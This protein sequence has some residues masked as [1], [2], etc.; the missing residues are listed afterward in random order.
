MMSSDSRLYL[1]NAEVVVGQRYTGKSPVKPAT[2]LSFKTRT[3]FSVEKTV[4]STPNNA[5]V[6]IYN[7]SQQSRT[8]LEQKNM[9]L[10]L[11]VGY[12]EALS[13]LFIGDITR[14]ETKRQGADVITS[15]ESG[16]GELALRTS[17][18]EISLEANATNVQAM[19]AAIDALNITLGSTDG[20]KTKVYKKGF[21]FSG[22]A[23]ELLDTLTRQLNLEW[24]VQDGELIILP[25]NGPDGQ[26][27]VVV[28]PDT[29]LI[30]FPTKTK[31]GL[32]FVSL[33]NPRIRPGRVVI[34]RSKQFYGVEM[35][36]SKFIASR[37]LKESGAIVKC[38]RVVYEGDTHEG[39]WQVKVEAIIPPQALEAYGTGPVAMAEPLR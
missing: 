7:L 4:E 2:G 1:R 3:N 13:T 39:N 20:I 27:A 30:G 34:V 33:L 29:G 21:T 17:H 12:Q 35:E 16:D 22:T 11:S 25:K 6:S 15:I 26:E 23:K 18:V 10:F 38:K 36:Q 32:E 8:F 9:V 31:D 28:T 24:S 37:A 14:I 19:K 5:K